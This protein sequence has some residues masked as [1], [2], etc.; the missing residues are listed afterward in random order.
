MGTAVTH[1]KKESSALKRKADIVEYTDKGNRRVI[2]TPV[3][4]EER[5]RWRVPSYDYIM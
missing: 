1:T 3:S 5:E 2:F 4:K